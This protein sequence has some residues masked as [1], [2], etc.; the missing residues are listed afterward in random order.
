MIMRMNPP[1][2]AKTRQ[3]NPVR[4]FSPILCPQQE[5]WCWTKCI[6]YPD[7]KE[8]KDRLLNADQVV[9]EVE[10]E[11]MEKLEP[12]TSRKKYGVV[13]QPV[14]MIID[15]KSG[16]ITYCKVVKV[17]GTDK[18]KIIRD[19]KPSPKQSVL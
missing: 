3:T 6:E 11:I 2:K 1:W 8:V 19:K 14:H 7:E 16:G 15:P 18:V 12:A 17:I 10:S 9:V 4:F 5:D 13:G